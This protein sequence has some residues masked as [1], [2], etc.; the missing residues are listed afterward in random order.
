MAW[1]G[2]VIFTVLILAIQEHGLF[3]HLFMSSLISFISVLYF[4]DYKSLTSLGRFIPRYFILFVAMVN[5]SVSLISLSDFL[6][7]VY[8]NARYFCRSEERRVGKEC[9]SRWSPYH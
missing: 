7:L 5:E 1:G 4:S 2:I 3:L 6:L 8:R 9:R